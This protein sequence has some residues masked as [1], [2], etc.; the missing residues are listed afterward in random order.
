MSKYNKNNNNSL[1]KTKSGFRPLDFSHFEPL[2]VQV[3]NGRFD[4]A[5]KIFKSIVQKEKILN[6]FNEKSRYEKP[7]VK[8]RRKSAEAQQRKLAAEVKQKLIESGEWEK[9]K[10]KKEELRLKSSKRSINGQTS[11]DNNE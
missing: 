3:R 7:S 4:E 11:S 8:K 9:R 6:L 5:C 1:Q 2:E 10:A